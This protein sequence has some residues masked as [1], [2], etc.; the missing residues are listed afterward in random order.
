M[1]G[2]FTKEA[3]AW[4]HYAQCEAARFGTYAVSPEHF[5]LALLR[6]GKDDPA[7]ALLKRMGADVGTLQIS[8]EHQ[9]ACARSG[10]QIWPPRP[11]EEGYADNVSAP[12]SIP[13]NEESLGEFAVDAYSMHLMGLIRAEA[14]RRDRKEISTFYFL[15]G[16]I[17]QD[18]IRQDERMAI[19]LFAGTDITLQSAREE[20]ARCEGYDVAPAA[21]QKP[22]FWKRLFGKRAVSPD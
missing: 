4:V 10:S 1:W 16:L 8:I 17:R 15:L 11:K 13:I 9:I 21:P 12:V 3:K 22:D 2:R 20:V 7:L 5:F 19:R 18:E 6:E 14:V